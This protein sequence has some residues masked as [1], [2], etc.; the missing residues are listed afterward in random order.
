MTLTPAHVLVSDKYQGP[1]HHAVFTISYDPPSERNVG[2]CSYV[3]ELR[4]DKR[5]KSALVSANLSYRE[6]ATLHAV[7]GSMLNRGTP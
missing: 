5:T 4:E 1:Y 7:I 3:V 2:D 6:L